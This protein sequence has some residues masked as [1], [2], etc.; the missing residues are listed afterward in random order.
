MAVIFEDGIAV[1]GV[2]LAGFGIW[3]SSIYQSHIP[4][5]IAAI[6]IAFLLGVVAIVLAYSNGQLLIGKA[7]SQSDELELK[8][9]IESLPQVERVATI[10]TT[11]VGPNRTQLTAEIEFHGSTFIDKNQ[12]YKDADRLKQGEDPIPILVDT[13]ERTVRILGNHINQIEKKIYQNFPEISS[14]ELEVN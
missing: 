11:V 5:A 9:F 3:L 8:G 6:I 2:L 12:I 4:D 1:L 7:M 14:I 13:T 10:K